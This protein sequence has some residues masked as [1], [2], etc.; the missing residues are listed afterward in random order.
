MG[1]IREHF[2]KIWEAMSQ[3]GFAVELHWSGDSDTEVPGNRHFSTAKSACPWDC[4][5][6]VKTMRESAWDAFWESYCDQ[7]E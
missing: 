5:N 6:T 4:K 7:K 3:E 1:E 2:S